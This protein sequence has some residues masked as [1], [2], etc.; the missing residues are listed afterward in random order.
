MKS[1]SDSNLDRFDNSI[2]TLRTQ[3]NVLDEKIV[4]LL[5][6]R[7][8]LVFQVRE[9]KHIDEIPQHSMEREH[10]VIEN[11]THNCCG[12]EKEYLAETYQ[13]LL[14]ATRK[15]ADKKDQETP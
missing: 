15:V 10:V 14:T 6:T 2:Q 11:A 8:Q 13:A 4:D 5:K 3:I 12:L 1:K 7:L 9:I